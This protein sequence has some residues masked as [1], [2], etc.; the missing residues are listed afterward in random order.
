[1]MLDSPNS[2]APLMSTIVILNFLFILIFLG[3]SLYALILLIK[4][5]KIYIKK[6]S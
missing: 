1:M 2:I 5:L 6:N 4:A 3:L